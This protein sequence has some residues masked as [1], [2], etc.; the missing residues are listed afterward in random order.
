MA[1]QRNQR[2]H[3][4]FEVYQKHKGNIDLLVE[5]AKQL[6]LS[7]G[8]VRGW[9]NKDK[10]DSKLNRTLQKNTEHSNSEK[11][12]INKEPMFEAVTEIDNPELTDK[13]RL[14]CIDHVHMLLEIPPKMSVSGF[15][16]F[17]KGKGLR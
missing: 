12:I 4:A 7:N 13:Q 5:I 3:K 11:N 8:T 15:M 1:R 14:F 17:L 6:D 10:W 9:K 16:G 2:R